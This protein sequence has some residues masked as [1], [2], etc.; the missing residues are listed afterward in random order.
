ML[1]Y[2]RHTIVVVMLINVNVHICIQ[3]KRRVGCHRTVCIRVLL[4][5]SLLWSSLT[6]QRP[7][8][9]PEAP[10]TYAGECLLYGMLVLTSKKG[11]CWSITPAETRMCSRTLFG[12][13]NS[14]KRRGW[15]KA[16]HQCPLHIG[17]GFAST[18]LAAVVESDP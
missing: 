16:S 18:Q 3:P 6:R 12:A 9:Q 2:Q 8:D 5:P 17:N 14:H 13:L 15:T 4:A 7:T 10:S 1:G 11:A